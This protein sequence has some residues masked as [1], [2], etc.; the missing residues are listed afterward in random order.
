MS[1]VASLGHA[2]VV[3][4]GGR[5]LCVVAA[6]CDAGDVGMLEGRCGRWWLRKSDVCHC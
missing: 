4:G 2:V 6:V 3:E 5:R 1:F